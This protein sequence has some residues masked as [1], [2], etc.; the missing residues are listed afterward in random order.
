MAFTSLGDY[1]LFF[2]C[3]LNGVGLYSGMQ[4]SYLWSVLSFQGLFLNSLRSSVGKESACNAGDPGLIP[5]L[6][7]SAG[8]GLGYPLQY[9]WTSLVAQLV[10]K[11]TC[12]AGDLVSTPGLGRSPG[13]GNSYPLQYSGLENS[14][15]CI[16]SPWGHKESDTNEWLSLVLVLHLGWVQ[17][18]PISEEPIQH[19]VHLL[20][21]LITLTRGNTN[22]IQ[23]HSA[24]N[25][26]AWFF[27]M[28]LSL[29]SWSLSPCM[30]KS[31]FSQRLK[32]ILF[33][34]LELFLLWKL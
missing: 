22:T 16:Y 5:G 31:V 34:F 28:I 18:A 15:D 24:G 2:L 27:V 20:N 33:I 6:G 23:P 17:S 7:R 9:S 30:C 1:S 10:K 19:L 13:E 12:N 8:E 21:G 25:C 4:F 11:S 14:M 3:S 29:A 32:R 26:L